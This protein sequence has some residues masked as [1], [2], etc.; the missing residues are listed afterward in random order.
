MDGVVISFIPCSVHLLKN[1]LLIPLYLCIISIVI[2]LVHILFRIPPL[3]KFIRRVRGKA[4]TR[5]SST[6]NNARTTTPTTLLEEIQDHASKRGGWTIVLSNA[7]RLTLCLV[8]FGLS[9]Y[10]AVL[11][12]GPED[13]FHKK[14]AH[15]GVESIK[16]G[17]KKHKGHHRAEQWFSYLEWLEIAQSTVYVGSS[18]GNAARMRLTSDHTALRVFP[19]TSHDFG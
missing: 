6:P 17:K 3:K 16:K 4:P 18:V 1:S 14:D 15:Y 8:L 12:P 13:K 9:I 11:A 5:S 19:R 10:A 7:A 2:L